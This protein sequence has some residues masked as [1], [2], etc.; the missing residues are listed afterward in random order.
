MAS[1]LVIEKLRTRSLDDIVL[2]STGETFRFD[3]PVSWDNCEAK[4]SPGGQEHP[5]EHYGRA[6]TD[7]AIC[8]SKVE[9]CTSI[10]MEYIAGSCALPSTIYTYFWWFQKRITIRALDE[11]P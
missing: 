9:S 8:A 3:F 11:V 5:L 7:A 4:E 6:L 2:S 1:E 10:S